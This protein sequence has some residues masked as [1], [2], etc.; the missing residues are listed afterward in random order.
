M[1]E[2]VPEEAVDAS[3]L[4]RRFFSAQNNP[5]DRIAVVQEHADVPPAVALTLLNRLYPVERR[6][7]VKMEML[8][9]LGDLDH[10]RDRDNQLALCTKALAPDQP[11]R[12]R[13]AAVHLLGDLGDP[14]GRAILIPLTRDNDREVR[15]AAVQ[16]LRDLRED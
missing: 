9:A 7:D 14:R 6:E 2:P 5:A 4:E 8:A 3:A 12:V 10:A 1:P 15:A 11:A 13:Y 16:V